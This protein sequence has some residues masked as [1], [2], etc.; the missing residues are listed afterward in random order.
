MPARTICD[1][2]GIAR[3][4]SCKT[5]AFLLPAIA[6]IEEQAPLQLDVASP[7]ALILAPYKRNHDDDNDDDDDD[8][9]DDADGV[10]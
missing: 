6:H 10:R 3:I 5:L 7:I 2:P 4:G 8:D 9:D 1:N